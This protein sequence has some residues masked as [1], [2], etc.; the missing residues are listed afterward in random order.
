M[1][2]SLLLLFLKEN[3]GKQEMNSEGASYLKQRN[4]AYVFLKSTIPPTRIRYL[5]ADYVIKHVTSM[6]SSV[7]RFQEINCWCF[8]N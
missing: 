2:I 3:K 4:N 7:R 6:N 1:V 5:V 8:T